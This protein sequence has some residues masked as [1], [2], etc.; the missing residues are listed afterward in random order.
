[1]ER[2]APP[3]RTCVGGRTI[4]LENIAATYVR[5][6]QPETFYFTAH[7]SP[8]RDETGNVAGVLV[9]VFDT[10]EQV[11]A[12]VSLQEREARTGVIVDQVTVGISQT[13]PAGRYLYVNDRYCEIVGRTREAVLDGLRVHDVT[14]PEDCPLICGV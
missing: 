4:S 5:F 9:Q 1:L 8:I 11:K 14:D 12:E 2:V 6:E 13:D 10:T 3:L 7:H